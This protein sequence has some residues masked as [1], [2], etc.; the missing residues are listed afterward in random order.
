MCIRDRS[1]YPGSGGT[2]TGTLAA[3]DDCTIVVRYSPTLTGTQTDTILVDYNDGA[4]GQTASRDVQGSGVAPAS[5]TIS[6]ADPYDYGTV[7]TGASTVHLFTLTN[8]GGFQATALAESGLG[9]DFDYTA[10][11]YPGAGG[12]CGTDL[13]PAVSCTIEVEFTPSTT[14]LRVETIDFSY[15]NGCLLYTSPS[16]RDRTRSRMPSSA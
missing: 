11:G 2:C 4:A 15:D 13:N 16:P 6:E 7:A 1:T 14:G 12:D 3:A 8:G 10:P 9:G 5:I